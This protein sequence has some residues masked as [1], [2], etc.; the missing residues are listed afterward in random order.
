MDERSLSMLPAN[1]TENKYL[2][3]AG[4]LTKMDVE[5]FVA[6]GSIGEKKILQ[7]MLKETGLEFRAYQLRTR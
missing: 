4:T 3:G 6:L 7:D 5:Q 2:S 1:S